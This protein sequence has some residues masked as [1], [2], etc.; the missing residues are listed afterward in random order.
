MPHIAPVDLSASD[1]A[2][3]DIEWLASATGF[4]ANSMLTLSHRPE[5]AKA[6]LGLVWSP[7]TVDP[8]LRWMVDHVTSFEAGRS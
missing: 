1:D 5:I 8:A 6:V 7:G 4:V 2:K 3:A